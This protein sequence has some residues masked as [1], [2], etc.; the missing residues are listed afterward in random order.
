MQNAPKQCRRFL[1]EGVRMDKVHPALGYYCR[2]HAVQ[3]AMKM[4]KTPETNDFAFSMIGG[5]E[6]QKPTESKEETLTRMKE[7]AMKAFNHADSI[8]RAGNANK[9]TIIAFTTAHVLLSVLKT[10]SDSGLDREDE[11]R[12]KYA[13]FKSMDISKALREGRIP[14]PG[15]PGQENNPEPEL[16]PE[17]AP[18][19]NPFAPASNFNPAPD[20]NSFAPQPAPD[21]NPFAPAASNFNPATEPAPQY[22]PKPQD[23]I[24][25]MPEDEEESRP[26][27]YENMILACAEAEQTMKHAFSAMR[28]NDAPAA[29]RKLEAAIRILKPY[30]Y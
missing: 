30:D 21:A 28:F 17:P 9:K 10:Q 26:A 13:I 15:P 14:T 18:D 3:M 12:L 20:M 7:I 8:D 6:S 27:N 19:A 4:P 5:L 29:L 24:P 23:N 2:L 25:Q 11:E 22:Q 16:E 1:R